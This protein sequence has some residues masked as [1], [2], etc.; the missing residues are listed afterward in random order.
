MIQKKEVEHELQATTTVKQTKTPVWIIQT[1]KGYR[2]VVETCDEETHH[3]TTILNASTTTAPDGASTSSSDSSFHERRWFEYLED[4]D[5]DDDD[6]DSD[7]DLPKLVA[8]YYTKQEDTDD[9]VSCNGSMPR[10]ANAAAISHD[11]DSSFSSDMPDL[12]QRHQHKPVG[13]SEQQEDLLYSDTI[14][15]IK[16]SCRQSVGLLYY[17]MFVSPASLISMS[18]GDGMA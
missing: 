9:D 10:L 11:E 13:T 12:C 6:D 16:C 2:S 4:S 14:N 1:N 18:G 15:I 3:G 8:R 17:N 5:D 7:D